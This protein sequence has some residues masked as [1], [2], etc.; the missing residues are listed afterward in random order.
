MSADLH[1]TAAIGDFRHA[2]RKRMRRSHVPLHVR[3]EAHETAEQVAR[4]LIQAV[5]DLGDRLGHR[6]IVSMLR[7][8]A[9][10][11]LSAA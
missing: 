9:D 7:R 11:E 1:M 6:T 8:A 4:T 3:A 2:V 5:P 10:D